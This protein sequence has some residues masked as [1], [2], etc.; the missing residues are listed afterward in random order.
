MKKVDLEN[1]GGGGGGPNLAASLKRFPRGD[2]CRDLESASE[3]LV[4]L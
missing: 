3:G 4:S 1:L 2:H